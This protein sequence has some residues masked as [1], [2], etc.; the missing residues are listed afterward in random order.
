[1]KD[2]R[3]DDPRVAPLDDLVDQQERLAVRDGVVDLLAVMAGRGSDERIGTLAATRPLAML[4][5]SAAR[6]CV[7]P[8]HP[9]SAFI[10]KR[11]HVV[12]HD[13]AVVDRP[14]P[15]GHDNAHAAGMVEAGDL[16]R[17]WPG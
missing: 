2:L 11:V 1:M 17:A 5:S 7:P 16:L 13:H 9:P 4:R 15:A 8:P 14:Q 12:G 3:A 6:S 10:K